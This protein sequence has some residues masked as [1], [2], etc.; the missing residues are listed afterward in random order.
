MNEDVRMERYWAISGWFGTVIASVLFA[1]A[2]MS[3]DAD[4][5]IM[6]GLFSVLAITCAIMSTFDLGAVARKVALLVLIVTTV[7][8]FIAV[9]G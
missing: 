3:H 8:T 5:A 7:G 6:W 1:Q 9:F 4:S 2:L